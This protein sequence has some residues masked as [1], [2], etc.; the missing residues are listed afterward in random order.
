MAVHPHPLRQAPSLRA[1]MLIRRPAAQVYQAIVDPA[2]TTRCWFSRASGPLQP[3]SSVTW[4]W[5]SYRVSA[6]AQV[7]ALQPN[8]LIRLRWPLPVEWQFDDRGDNTTM[9]TINAS[10]FSPDDDGVAQ[11][12]DN[13]GGFMLVLAG[14]KAWLEHGIALNLVNDKA[15]YAHV[16]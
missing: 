6:T 15:P 5:D 8:R 2:I 14:C 3:G 1:E 10:D 16:R 7:D 13:M 11:A 12:I 9:T 4:Y